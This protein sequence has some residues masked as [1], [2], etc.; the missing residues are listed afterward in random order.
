MNRHPIQP[1]HLRSGLGSP[2]RNR[3]D[4]GR[5]GWRSGVRRLVTVWLLLVGMAAPGLLPETVAQG[6]IFFN[7]RNNWVYGP[8]LDPGGQALVSGPDYA[9]GLWAGPDADSL[10]PHGLP[11][12]LGTGPRAGYFSSTLVLEEV[13]PATVLT[14]QVRVWNSAVY[15]SFEEARAAG[16]PWG[17]SDLL[18]IT[19]APHPET[20]VQGPAGFLIGLEPFALIPEPSTAAMV[21]I[22][23]L[24]LCASRSRDRQPSGC[25]TGQDRNGMGVASCGS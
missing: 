21:L 23:L 24:L 3:P 20:G 25:E 12:P 14:A 1:P 18:V 7:N 15:G 10:R 4:A 19:T 9:A 16:S 17:M 6:L 13:P 8:V 2:V 11:A 5:H 22:G